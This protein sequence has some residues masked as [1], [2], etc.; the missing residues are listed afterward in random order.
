MIRHFNSGCVDRKTEA[1]GG[2][3]EKRKCKRDV[4]GSKCEMEMKKEGK[5][6]RRE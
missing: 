2:G 1:G 3:R 6:R 4:K 5:A